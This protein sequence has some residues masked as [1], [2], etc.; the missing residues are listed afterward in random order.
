MTDIELESMPRALGVMGDQQ[1]TSKREQ[2]LD[3]LAL[4]LPVL[5]LTIGA[6]LID[7]TF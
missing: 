2:A 3:A 5:V 6:P 1:H 4:M 7:M